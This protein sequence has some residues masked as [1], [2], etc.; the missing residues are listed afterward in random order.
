MRGRIEYVAEV[1][2]GVCEQDMLGLAT[3]HGPMKAVDVLRSMGWR[4]TRAHGWTCPD[5]LPQSSAGNNTKRGE[6]TE[7]TNMQEAKNDTA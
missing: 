6:D 2:C 3:L 1:S 5:C 4:L 7:G